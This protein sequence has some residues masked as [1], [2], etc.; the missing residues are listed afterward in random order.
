[1]FTFVFIYRM[2][3]ELNTLKTVLFQIETENH[4]FDKFH[5]LV[6]QSARERSSS[7]IPKLPKP[8]RLLTTNTVRF[9][10]IVS[11]HRSGENKVRFVKFV[12]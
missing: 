1:M 8:S 9:R 11:F 7:I 10:Y 3:Q 6:L 5:V 2:K 12:T 4:N